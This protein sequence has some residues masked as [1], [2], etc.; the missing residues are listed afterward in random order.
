MTESM[1]YLHDG[2]HVAGDEEDEEPVP[3]G[4]LL[5]QVVG[6]VLTEKQLFYS[7]KWTSYNY[8]LLR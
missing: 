5:N 7:R 2:V 8:K 6:L 3:D 4:G 1:F